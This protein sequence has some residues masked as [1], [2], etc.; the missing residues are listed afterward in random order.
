[1][2]EARARAAAYYAKWPEGP[3]AAE[4]ERMTGVRRR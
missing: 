3:D 1:M 4:L 2:D